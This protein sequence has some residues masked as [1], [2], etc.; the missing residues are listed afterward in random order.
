MDTGT[1]NLTNQSTIASSRCNDLDS[2]HKNLIP[3]LRLVHRIADSKYIHGCLASHALRSI[4][5]KK[6][7]EE[8]KGDV[9]VNG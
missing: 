7:R 5:S 2:T 9:C 4:A 8:S 1:E 3:G 6:N